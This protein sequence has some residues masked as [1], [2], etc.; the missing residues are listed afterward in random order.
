MFLLLCFCCSTYKHRTGEGYFVSFHFISRSR[1]GDRLLIY[2]TQWIKQGGLYFCTYYFHWSNCYNNIYIIIMM[3][4]DPQII[5]KNHL[6][7]DDKFCFYCFEFCLHLLKQDPSHDNDSIT[8]FLNPIQ[9]QS[10]KYYDT[11]PIQVQFDSNNQ[12]LLV[13]QTPSPNNDSIFLFLLIPSTSVLMILLLFFPRICHI[14]MIVFIY[15][16]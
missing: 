1:E 4:A 14:M 11:V 7:S 13:I 2:L 15:C 12:Q 10:S 8:L 6:A 16:C 3:A 9:V 5:M